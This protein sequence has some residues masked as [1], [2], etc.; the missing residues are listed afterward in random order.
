MEDNR[1]PHDDDD[2]D[3][4]GDAGGATTPPTMMPPEARLMFLTGGPGTGKSA[5]VHALASELGLE[6]LTWD[7]SHVEYSHRRNDDDEDGGTTIIPYASQLSS[8]EEFLTQGGAGM[9]SLDL[10]EDDDDDKD[11]DTLPQRKK[12]KKKK[13]KKKQEDETTTTTKGGDDFAGSLILVEEVRRFSPSHSNNAANPSFPLLSLGVPN[14]FMRFAH[15]CIYFASPPPS[16]SPNVRNA[17]SKIP[18]L[19]NHESEQS[20]R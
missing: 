16:Y 14:C 10:L 4:D 20:F 15:I 8:F 9:S 11:D 5:S 19:Y 1:L 2:G 13:K 3:G 6:V 18:N 7:D 17:H 12:K